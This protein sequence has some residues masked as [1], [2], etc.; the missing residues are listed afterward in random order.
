[1]GPDIVEPPVKV[2]S[3]QTLVSLAVTAGGSWSRGPLGLPHTYIGRS[4][5]S[6][7]PVASFG[8]SYWAYSEVRKGRGMEGL[9]AQWRGEEGNED[10]TETA[11]SR[12]GH[13]GSR[14]SSAA[15]RGQRIMSQRKKGTADQKNRGQVLQ[16][17]GWLPWLQGKTVC[18]VS[19]SLVLSKV[20]NLERR[21]EVE[22]I[23]GSS[24]R[25]IL[26]VRPLSEFHRSPILVFWRGAQALNG[27]STHLRYSRY[28]AGLGD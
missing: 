21:A 24:T 26:A 23:L 6:A 2:V 16:E 3:V 15:R 12:E 8:P 7:A 4:G 18:F 27:L 22:S 1:M 13:R 10:E 20:R 11:V 25:P 9:E 19:F 5:Q 17:I 28:L 14:I